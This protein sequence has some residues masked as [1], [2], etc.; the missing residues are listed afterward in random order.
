MRG[1]ENRIKNKRAKYL[2]SEIQR[3]KKLN[4]TY[5]NTLDPAIFAYADV[6]DSYNALLEQEQ[7][8]DVERFSKEHL[9]N[10][11]KLRKSMLDLAKYLQLEKLSLEVSGE[12]PDVGGE[13]DEDFDGFEL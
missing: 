12:S 6:Y 10:K 5:T 4:E 7:R 8:G 3:Q 9:D 1:L 2:V 13:A 11:A